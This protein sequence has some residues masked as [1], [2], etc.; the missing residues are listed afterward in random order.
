[1]EAIGV[2]TILKLIEKASILAGADKDLKLRPDK[3]AE[4]DALGKMA[5]QIQ[6]A[7]AK[8][9][10]DSIAK[11]AAQQIAKMQQEIE[12]L[13]AALTKL[14]QEIHPQ[15]PAPAP[16]APPPPQQNV[17]PPQAGPPGIGAPGGVEQVP[18]Q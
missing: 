17:P 14:I 4:L 9:A 8:H 12:G 3:K 15:Q 1:M 6:I 7:A 13:N 11:P 16:Q 5:E 2:K 18:T 10:E